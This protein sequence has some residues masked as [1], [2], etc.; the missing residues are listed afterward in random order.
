MKD[1]DML[2]R[3]EKWRSGGQVGLHV[4]ELRLTWAGNSAGTDHT[5][6]GLRSHLALPSLK[7]HNLRG[8]GLSVGLASVTERSEFI[9]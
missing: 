5:V 1:S 6:H 3:K 7:A 8:W 2:K 9:A 4:S